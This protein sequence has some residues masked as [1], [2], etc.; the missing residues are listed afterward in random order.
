MRGFAYRQGGANGFYLNGAELMLQKWN[1]VAVTLK[2]GT[3]RT[4]VNGAIGHELSGVSAPDPGTLGQL[5]LGAGLSPDGYRVSD[6]SYWIREVRVW[7]RA[8]D[9]P[10]LASLASQTLTGDEPGL[11][12]YWPLDEGAGQVATDHGPNKLDL[13]MGRSSEPD[14]DEPFWV[15][16]G[17]AAQLAADPYYRISTSIDFDFLPTRQGGS[18][19]RL[20]PISLGEDGLLSVLLTAG[21]QVVLP[22]V[23]QPMKTFTNDGTGVMVDTTEQTISG[24][25]PMIFTDPVVNFDFNGDGRPDVFLGDFGPDIHPF[26]G[27]QDRMFIQTEAGALIDDTAARLPAVPTLTHDATGA[28]VDGDGDIDVYTAES[29]SMAERSPQMLINDGSGI[30]TLEN[31]R[32]PQFVRDQ[33]PVHTASAFSDVDRDGDADLLLGKQAGFETADQISLLLNDGTGNFTK[34]PA[35]SVDPVFTD[36]FSSVIRI[37]PADLNLDGWPDFI[38][39]GANSSGSSPQVDEDTR[40]QLN[41]RNGTFKDPGTRWDR[42]PGTHVVDVAD[43]NDDGWPDFFVQAPNGALMFNRG[44]ANF[45]NRTYLFP[46]G[47]ELFRSTSS[48]LDG[49]HDLDIVNASSILR[50]TTIKSVKPVRVNAIPAPQR[51]VAASMDTEFV[52][53]VWSETARQSMVLVRELTSG[54]ILGEF[55]AG[56]QQWIGGEL[57]ALPG[58]TG[59]GVQELVV[60]ATGRDGTI[61]AS[62][63]DRAGNS[64]SEVVF[65]S[66][67]WEHLSFHYAGDEN[68]QATLAVFAHRPGDGSIAA[69]VRNSLNG[70]LLANPIFLDENWFPVDGLVVDDINGNAEPELAILAYN[71]DREIVVET[72]DSD[73]S[74]VINTASF[75]DPDW[76]PYE[77]RTVADFSGNSATE[78]ALLAEKKDGS[79]AV[80][81]RDSLTGTSLGTIP[82]HTNDWAPI[83]LLML[84]DVNDN[85]VAELAV[86]ASKDTQLRTEIRDASSGELISNFNHFTNG[87]F[88]Y[89][90]LLIDDLNNDASIDIGVVAAE[91]AT[92]KASVEVRNVIDGQLSTVLLI[93]QPGSVGVQQV[94]TDGFE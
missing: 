40:L 73:T 6:G 14:D 84:P 20:Y 22:P 57:L 39:T 53:L 58:N 65:F 69:E 74:A 81:L 17:L 47:F 82:F 92:G 79:L 8:L 3:V 61:R 49:D 12:A 50:L 44:N 16:A 30:F 9:N 26:P 85:G 62:M 77:I 59:V 72:R 67:D 7:S 37:F 88:G 31:D 23:P 15:D 64:A 91:L 13:M 4:W 10:E 38:A 86:L 21:D 90:L 89:H 18:V 93:Y 29:G 54:A 51:T 63:F 5:S 35:T 80:E 76:F 75:F 55:L 87:W 1:H 19:A 11:V 43:L 33:Q 46:T 60:L 71:K 28:D 70:M 34:A 94:F 42:L 25:E 36:N 27:A 78:Y 32:L 83:D 48:D 45:V 24:I 68:D 41:Q 66:P 2:E 56:N 52:S